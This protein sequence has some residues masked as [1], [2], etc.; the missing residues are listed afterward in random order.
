MAYHHAL[1]SIGDPTRRSVLEQLRAG[2][3]SV[4]EIARKLPV[5]RPAVS[6]HLS[7]LLDAG[8]VTEK[9]HGRERRISGV[10]R[11]TGR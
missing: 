8:L 3:Q 7:V 2:P 6:H 1:R 11:D 5:S 9:R 4:G 10:G